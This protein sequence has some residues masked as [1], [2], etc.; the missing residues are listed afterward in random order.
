MCSF[1]EH[2]DDP[3]NLTQISPRDW[4]IRL[5]F[6]MF[7]NASSTHVIH[8][9][10]IRVSLT[11]GEGRSFTYLIKMNMR[12]TTCLNDNHSCSYD[13]SSSSS[14]RENTFM[15]MKMKHT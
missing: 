9:N 8:S 5:S 14:N 4:K 10:A 11:N 12:M 1:V 3:M 7:V 15:K 2:I 6:F 13:S